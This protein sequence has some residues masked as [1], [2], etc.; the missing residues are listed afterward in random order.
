MTSK[1]NIFISYARSDGLPFSRDLSRR[2]QE[3]GLAV[4]RDLTDIEGGRGWWEQIEEAI[5]SVDHLILV[6][7]PNA[8]KSKI[9]MR[10]WRLARAQG[11]HVRPVLAIKDLNL[12]NAPR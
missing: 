8:L 9:I 6:L 10:E 5:R 2:L 1:P 7:S 11:V 12:S 3:E 4:W